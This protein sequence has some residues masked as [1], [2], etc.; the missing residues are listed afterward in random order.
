LNSIQNLSREGDV[1]AQEKRPQWGSIRL[2]C[3]LEYKAKE[4][5]RGERGR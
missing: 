3:N 2:I 4:R 5:R 1:I